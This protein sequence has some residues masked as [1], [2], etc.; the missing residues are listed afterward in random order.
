V[1]D[2]C[3]GRLAGELSREEL[4]DEGVEAA[5]NACVAGASVAAAAV[6][7]AAFY[8]NPL[9]GVPALRSL[10]DR[11]VELPL[12]RAVWLRA[13]ARAAHPETGD[14][15]FSPGFGFVSPSEATA[16]LGALKRLLTPWHAVRRSCSAFFLAHRAAITQVSGPL[17]ITGLCAF[18][19]TDHGV[20][21]EDA[22]GL[23][24]VLRIEPALREAQRTRRLGLPALP[25]YEHPYV[26][27]GSAPVMRTYD[28]QRLME[29]VGL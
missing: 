21:P 28:V 10:M 18:F 23:F 5:R 6:T 8:D 7:A 22:E 27:E 11:L 15:G 26:Y 4:F 17:N 13:L 25:F 9:T 24:L 19:L 2:E 1:N 16:V 14:E 12:E 20:S 3:R 29:E